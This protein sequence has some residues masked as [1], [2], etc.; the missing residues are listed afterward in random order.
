M[1]PSQ[2]FPFEQYTLLYFSLITEYLSNAWFSI[3]CLNSCHNILFSIS[4]YISIFQPRLCI[5]MNWEF[6]LNWF[7]SHTLVRFVFRRS[8]LKSRLSLFKNVHRPLPTPEILWYPV[9]LMQR[10]LEESMCPFS[11]L[12][13]FQYGGPISSQLCV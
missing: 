1:I 6:F 3:F 7:L 9:P 12:G 8:E 5:R 10:Y 13:S 2:L 11:S 4:F